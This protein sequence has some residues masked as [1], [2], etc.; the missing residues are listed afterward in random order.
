V[1][2]I[3]FLIFVILPT[4][5][6]SQRGVY[7]DVKIENLQGEAS[8]V[9]WKLDWENKI[10]YDRPR[11]IESKD[12]LISV[13]IRVGDWAVEYR[14]GDDIYSIM[15]LHIYETI[16]FYRYTIYYGYYTNDFRE[17]IIDEVNMKIIYGDF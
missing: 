5:L 13:S 17:R 7:L 12:S 6:F 4:I 16:E 10:I 9:I 14:I 3:L 2:K 15:N 1:R 11:V 8:I